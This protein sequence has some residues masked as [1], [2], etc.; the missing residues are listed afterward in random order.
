S[1]ARERGQDAYKNLVNAVLRRMARDGEGWINRQRAGRLNTPDWLWKS[2]VSAYG[3]A[4]AQAIAEAHLSEA[5]IDITVTGDKAWWADK[6]E[7]EV[8]P[9]GSLRRAAGGRI[10][11]LPGFSEGAWWVQDAAAALPAR[12]LGDVTG[13]SIADLCAA[14]GGKTAQLAAA[15]AQVTAV[16]RSESRLRRLRENMERLALTV[17]VVAAD[18]IAWT[19]S[20]LFDSVLL[21]APCSATGTLRRHPDA[22]RLKTSTDTAKL[23]RVQAGLFKAA[24]KMLK[25]GGTLVYCV[26]SLQP[27]EGPGLIGAALAGGAPLSRLPVQAEE[28]GGLAEAITPEGDVRTLPCHWFD[29]GGMDGFFIARLRKTL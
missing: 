26:C 7:A 5:P 19:P 4:T 3:E 16:D 23:A 11:E 27:E 28:I 22:A 17:E 10:E 21:D 1:L 8:L 6:L 25:P 15:G 29:R 14:P 9:T 2:W 20:E 24:V 12:L 18:A 13:Q